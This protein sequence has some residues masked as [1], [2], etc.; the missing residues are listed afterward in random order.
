MGAYPSFDVM[1]ILQR[2]NKMYANTSLKSLIIVT[3]LIMLS[4]IIDH[5]F[6]KRDL[7]QRFF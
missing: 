2:T 7:Q 5:I 1:F 3:V 6:V 4:N